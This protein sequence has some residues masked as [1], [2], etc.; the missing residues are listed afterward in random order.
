MT[1]IVLV[2]ELSKIPRNKIYVCAP[3]VCNEFSLFGYIVA[4]DENGVYIKRWMKC[5]RVYCGIIYLTN[6][7]F[8]LYY[9]LYYKEGDNNE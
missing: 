5:G 3:P 6:D 1:N 4:R 7:E 9:R 2:G 8:E